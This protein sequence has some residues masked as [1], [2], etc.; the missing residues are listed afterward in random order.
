[1]ADFAAK[2]E[3]PVVRFVADS[4]K[5]PEDFP[6]PF[7]ERPAVLVFANEYDMEVFGIDQMEHALRLI[8]SPSR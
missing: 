2:L 7:F 6:H 4:S 8:L 3:I 5:N 1:M